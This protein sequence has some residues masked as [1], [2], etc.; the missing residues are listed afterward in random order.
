MRR[1]LVISVCLTVLALGGARTALAKGPHHGHGPPVVRH[2]Y[3][4]R[5]G[6]WHTGYRGYT[7]YCH[8]RP[9]VAAYPAYPVY[10]RPGFGYGYPQ[11]GFGIAGRNFSF[12]LQQ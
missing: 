10:P 5:G 4:H 3:P 6:S 12:W 1:L 9:H 7:P 8:T 11:L 2:G